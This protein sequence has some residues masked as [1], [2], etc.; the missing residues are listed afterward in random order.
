[1]AKVTDV[2]V[3]GTLENL[4]FYRRMGKSCSRAKRPHIHQTGPTKIRS[5]NF[6]IAA[7][8]AKALR[9]GLKSIMPLPTDRSMQSRFSGAIAKWLALSDIDNLPVGDAPDYFSNF[10]FAAGAAFGERCKVPVQIT[11]P[12]TG[13]ITV[14]IGAFIPSEKIKAPAGTSF[15]KL[16]ITVT[17]CI[18]KSGISNGTVTQSIMIPYNDILIPAQSMDFLLPGPPGSITV[19]AARLQ[20]YKNGNTLFHIVNDVAWMPAGIINAVYG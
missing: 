2:F 12:G 3:S 8:A 18:L 7:R 9:S 1:M 5:L 19:T 15:V 11:M 6:G 13:Y 20:Y 16:T 4:V 14:G 10:Q 17:G